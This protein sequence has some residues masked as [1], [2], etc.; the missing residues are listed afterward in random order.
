[1]L[2]KGQ[3]PSHEP[4][5][6]IGLVLPEDHIGSYQITSD[7]YWILYLLNIRY[8]QILLD[9]PPQC[10][11]LRPRIFRDF[12]DFLVNSRFYYINIPHNLFIQIDM[13]LIYIFRLGL[14]GKCLYRS[15]INPYEVGAL[16][17][18]TS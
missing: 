5:V 8:H 16:R 17:A 11:R 15:M 12:R 18:P 4:V 1:M 2:V 9:T 6:S 10:K 3:I 13:T 14:R 7:P